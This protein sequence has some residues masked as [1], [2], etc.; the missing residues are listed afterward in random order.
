MADTWKIE[1][2]KN[3]EFIVERYRILIHGRRVGSGI[4]TL[5]IRTSACEVELALTLLELDC[6]LIIGYTDINTTSAIDLIKRLEIEKLEKMRVSSCL[7]LASRLPALQ[8]EH[9]SYVD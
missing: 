9:I 5:L 3:L 2:R 4:S 7:T 8:F 1:G 6:I